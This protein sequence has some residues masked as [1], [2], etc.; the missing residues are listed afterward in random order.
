MELVE[1]LANNGGACGVSCLGHCG[2]DVRKVIQKL[3]ITLFQLDHHV[4]SKYIQ[5]PAPPF[6]FL[7]PRLDSKPLDPS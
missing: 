7:A 5:S 2:S 4:D 3:G 6:Q 1:G